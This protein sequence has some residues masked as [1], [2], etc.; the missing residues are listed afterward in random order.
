[1]TDTNKKL[2]GIGF[3]FFICAMFVTPTLDNCIAYM[4]GVIIAEIALRYFVYENK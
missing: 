2:L 1:M 4:I 3:A